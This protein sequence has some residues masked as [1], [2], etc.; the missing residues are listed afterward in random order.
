MD[1][2]FDHCFTS[3]LR[4]SIQTAN[5]IMDEL[6]QHHIKVVRLWKLNERFYGNLTG[7][8]KIKAVEKFGKDQVKQWRRQHDCRPPPMDLSNHY[9]PCRDKKYDGLKLNEIPH[10]ECLNDVINRVSDVT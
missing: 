4:R 5:I 3:V 2:K 10:S 1:I 6:G 9:H 7:M 8:N